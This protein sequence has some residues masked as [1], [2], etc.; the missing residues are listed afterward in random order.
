[1]PFVI[2]GLK[3]YNCHHGKNRNIS[4]KNKAKNEKVMLVF[5]LSF[6]LAHQHVMTYFLFCHKLS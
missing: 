3:E 6:L 4:K 1:M 2:A 5:L